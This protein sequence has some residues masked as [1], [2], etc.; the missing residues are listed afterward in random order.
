MRFSHVNKSL[1][2]LALAALAACGGGGGGGGPAAFVP[3]N[4]GQRPDGSPILARIV[5]VGDS[6]TAGYQA[7]GFL[8]AT[9]LKN[10]I[11][12]G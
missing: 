10:P 3:G 5:G 4:G 8:G 1:A 9:N 12:P 2:V 11:N 6:L 7:D